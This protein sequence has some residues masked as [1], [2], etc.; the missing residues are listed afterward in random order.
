MNENP[1]QF[2][3]QDAIVDFLAWLYGDQALFRGP[4]GLRYP[5]TVETQVS[6]H[7]EHMLGDLSR[8]TCTFPEDTWLLQDMK[9]QNSYLWNGPTYALHSIDGPNH[10]LQCRVGSYFDTVN[11]CTIL[12][13]ELQRAIA[14]LGPQASHD[15]RYAAMPLRYALHQGYR[16]ARALADAWTGRGRSAAI[17]ISCLFA[18]FDGHD[19]RYFVRQR[20]SRL[21]DGAGLHHIV[22]SMVF[23]PTGNDPADPASYSL[24]NTILREVAEEL[25]N[26]EEGDQNPLHYPEITDLKTLLHSGGADLTISGLAMDLLCLR[27]EILAVL[28]VHDPQW[29]ARHAS[30]LCFSRHEYEQTT[31]ETESWHSVQNEALFIRGGDLEPRRCI[32][33]GAASAILGLPLV[34]QRYDRTPA[35]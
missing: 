31:A 27:P 13:V 16:G 18:V 14:A 28:V 35:A 6:P 34:R 17:A 19:Y 11:T 33:A 7:A 12:E 9:Q 32:A 15:E 8:E 3:R 29:L 23:Q 22:P 25:F 2:F 10:Q 30:S 26:R 20:S 1:N 21:A 4:T 5:L 24:K